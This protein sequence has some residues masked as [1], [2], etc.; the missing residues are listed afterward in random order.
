MTLF[1]ACI[2]GDLGWLKANREFLGDINLISD[3]DTEAS[4]PIQHAVRHG[5]IDIVRWLITDSGKDVDF[6]IGDSAALREAAA[7]GNLEIIRYLVE[8]VVS[9][10]TEAANRYGF[11]PSNRRV[12][13]SVCNH[14][15]IQ[16]AAQYG[17]LN[18]I[19]YLIED[20]GQKTDFTAND[21]HAVIWAAIRGYLDIVKYLVFDAIGAGKIAAK[22]YGFEPLTVNIDVTAR[23]NLATIY[24][25]RDGQ[26]TTLRWLVLESGQPISI[27][28]KQYNSGAKFL[29]EAYNHPECAEFCTRIEECFEAGITLER[30]QQ[31]PSLFCLVEKGIEPK[32]LSQLTDSDI[33][34]L[35][36]ASKSPTTK[37]YSMHL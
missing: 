21:N 23:D 22:K 36:L 34:N 37:A 15:P 27:F 13:I 1:E 11:A 30:L 9:D 10:S 35:A 6:T 20:S 17:H 3:E 26:Y 24:S 29:A 14:A 25:A 33:I 5:H 32:F 4:Y 31:V 2:S 19:R 16:L 18:V 7:V 12:D 28:S 8:A